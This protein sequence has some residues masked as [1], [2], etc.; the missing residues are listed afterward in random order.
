MNRR[1]TPGARLAASAVVILRSVILSGAL[2]SVNG[3]ALAEENAAALFD[4]S[5]LLQSDA[6]ALEKPWAL[7]VKPHN[8][9]RLAT[10]KPTKVAPRAAPSRPAARD[11]SW[12]ATVH[13]AKP[14]RPGSMAAVPVAYTP[15]GLPLVSPGSITGPAMG[16][17]TG[18]ASFYW[19]EQM[20]ASGER[21][22][23]SA[24][25]AA[26]KTLPMHTRVRVTRLDTG[27]SVLVRI[28]D[29]GPFKPGRIIDLSDAAADALGMKAMGLA[30]V[31]IDVVR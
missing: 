3:A 27:R 18:I 5:W 26:H 19:Q 6:P 20:T 10:V 24:M 28:N 8:S 16:P 12:P 23:K 15:G 13:L 14:Q 25:T 22:D 2:C 17:A 1:C 7:G 4:L 29:R 31:K 9:V 21:F 11:S 30:Q